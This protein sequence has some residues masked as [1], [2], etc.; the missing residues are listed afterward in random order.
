MFQLRYKSFLCSIILLLTGFVTVEA[1][2]FESLSSHQTTNSNKTEQ[3]E[4]IKIG[5]LIPSIES[6]SAKHGAELAIKISN[7]KGGYKDVP[8]QLITRSTAGPWGAGSKESVS[9]VYDDEVLAIMGSLDGRNAHLAEQVAAKTKIIFLSTRASDM[10]LSQAFVPWYFRTVPNDKQQAI[11]LIQEI[12]KNGESENVTIISTED[13]DSK[14]A[15]RTFLKVAD[16]MKIAKPKHF[17]LKSSGNNINEI[18][19]EIEKSDAGKIVLFGDYQ[20]ASKII[21][22]LKERNLAQTIFGSLSTINNLQASGLN[23]E[24]FEDVILISSGH[25]FTETG[26]AFQKEF[27]KTFG[28]LP[29]F[30]SAF[31]YDGIN[32]IID[33]IKRAGPDRDKI[34][35]AFAE[36]K[37]K[38]GVTGNIQFDKN[39]NRVGNPGLMIIKNGF[40]VVLK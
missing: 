8:F 14:Y 12:Y 6:Q 25:Y 3:P 26:L 33:V 24:I 10:T 18:L 23:W 9:L 16:S 1:Q 37:Y 38:S 19:D 32:I 11:S 17:L 39:G 34:I 5:L 7:E 22:A 29:G 30:F 21:P 36:T 13:Y 40:P 27:E 35:D 4:T 20:F 2:T 15:V 28:Y 31:A